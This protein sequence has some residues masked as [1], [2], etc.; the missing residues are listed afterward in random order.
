MEYNTTAI[1]ILI[2]TFV[3]SMLCRL[4]IVFA[5]LLSTIVTTAYVGLPL[6]GAFQNLTAGMNSF[7]FMAIPCFIFAGEV[8][9][10]GGI[11]DGIV[12]FSNALVGW[13][14]GGLA[15][16]NCVSSA[17]FGGVSGSPSAD[18]ASVGGL[19]MRTMSKQGYDNEF[20][21]SV[22][23][24]TATLGIIIPPSQNMIMYAM[25]AGST[26]SIGRLF[27]AGYVPGIAM[28]LAMMLYCGVVSVKRKYPKGERFNFI[29]LFKTF[30]KAFFALGMIAIICLGVIGGVFTATE[31]ASVAAIY[32][33]LVAI[34][35]YRQMSF[36][37]FIMCCRNAL[38]TLTV[39]IG[40]I[41]VSTAFGWLVAYLRIPAMLTEAILSIT[42]SKI[43]IMILVN[44]LLL[45][46]GCFMSIAS[47]IM[48]TT[49][50]LLPIVMKIGIDP[51]QFGIIMIMNLGIGLLTPPVGGTLYVGCAVSGLSIGKLSK[52]LLPF[53]LVMLLVLVLINIFPQIT[54]ALPNMVMPPL[55]G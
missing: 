7:T 55:G 46:L 35:V 47:V 14:R 3:V 49:P 42:S 21:T 41:A 28:C 19:V 2:V 45:F 23:T 33:V 18:I 24:A 13:M 51:I 5:M 48:I 22:T 25:A 40:L 26:V 31:S 9:G 27:M 10:N 1:I 11:S 52:A 34:I 17:F 32:A 44:L 36:K 12:E 43:I 15:Q 50:I 54:M 6:M 4:H 39:V 53:Y 38:K 16:V 8:M 30:G 37:K 20:S 29:R